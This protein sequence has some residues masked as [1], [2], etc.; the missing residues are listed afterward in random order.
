[1]KAIWKKLIAIAFC[2]TTAA[3][4]L[5][6]GVSA[7]NPVN[8][9]LIELGMFAESSKSVEIE[10]E[11]ESYGSVY[12]AMKSEN[13]NNGDVK[14]DVTFPRGISKK[15]VKYDWYGDCD[16][17]DGNTAKVDARGY[18]SIGCNVTVSVTYKNWRN[19]EVTVTETIRVSVRGY[20]WDNERDATQAHDKY[21]YD[22]SKGGYYDDKWYDRDDW[23]RD[24]VYWYDGYYYY[25]AG[26]RWHA[27]TSYPGLPS[28]GPSYGPSYS[29]SYEVSWDG[30]SFYYNGKVQLPSAYVTIGGKTIELDVKLISG[31]GKS[32]GR[33]RVRAS[34][35]S[36]YSRYDIT[37]T[38]FYYEIKEAQKEGF[39]TENG[40]TYYYENGRKVTGWKTI[41]GT[42][43]YFLN[44]GSA[45]DG[46]VKEGPADWYYFSGGQ[47]V[48][49]W[50]NDNGTTYYCYGNGKM[51][52][53]RWHE[54]GGNWYYFS[55]SGAM[56][57]SR[58][59]LDKGK[60]YYVAGD[61]RMARNTTVPGG[62]KVDG[63][64]VWVK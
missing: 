40:N 10:D 59:I 6:V 7:A 32:V 25:Y 2:A 34:L 38:T 49:G 36:R 23:D 46:W 30:D 51:C 9:N 62:Y 33:H 64:G 63:N 39:V 5:S 60:W 24:K 26:G 11:Y 57:T 16:H 61:G 43:Y 29:K 41:K 52:R 42:Q 45:A 44:D 17:K 31:D 14:V 13:W 56:Q 1:M 28:Y 12:V 4:M 58:W 15:S 37:G 22:D 50:I 27:T 20:A 47:M 3:S 48:T 21:S 55:E 18:Y 35:P 53:G 54:I 19:R 8:P